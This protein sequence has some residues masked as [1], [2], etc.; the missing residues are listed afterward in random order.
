MPGTTVTAARIQALRTRAQRLDATRGT[1]PPQTVVS[2]LVAVQAQDLAAATLGVGVRADALTA[3]DVDRARN[4]ERSIV[5]TWCLR[6][7]LHLVAASDVRWL[8]EV[9]RPGLVA[10]NRTRRR[11][12]GLDDADTRRGVGLLHR[13]LANGPRTRPEIAAHLAEHGVAWK[14]QA[15]IHLIWRAAIDGLV[16]YGPDRAGESTFV[17][18]DDWVADGSSTSPVA[19]PV[20]ELARRFQAA[21]GPA[22]PEDFAAWSGLGRTAIDRAWT[23]VPVDAREP[24]ALGREVRLL[25][26][27]DAVWLAYRDH[28]WLVASEFQK[29]LF[30][31]GGVL[32]RMVY[33]GGRAVGTW[34]R[35]AAGSTAT[36]R[37]VDVGVDL[38]DSV[39][40][41]ELAA[42]AAELGRFLETP[43]RL[44][45]RGAP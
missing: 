6:G 24:P 16:C 44:L 4:V 36:R 27:F 33:R 30:P 29:R 15:T 28:N 39:D 9:V 23:D 1:A 18:L 19:D 41:A 8:L 22:A 17:L 2:H 26:A 12:L 42:A 38:F 35:R 45:A 37:W 3:A 10:A 11:E 7:T 31:G 14:G 25:P 20:G 40:P 21:Y 5:R 13:Y 34:S 43:A 32:R